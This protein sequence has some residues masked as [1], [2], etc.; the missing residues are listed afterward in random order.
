[1]ENKIYVDQSG[2]YLGEYSIGNIAIPA[3]AIEISL[4]PD[5]A[6]KIYN[7]DSNSWSYSLQDVKDKK[8]A[9]IKALRNLE[10]IKPMTSH[11]AREL[12]EQQDGSFIEGSNKYFVFNTAPTGN[13][14]TEPSAICFSIIL[15]NLTNPTYKLRYSCT[16]IEGENTRKGYVAIDAALASS[17]MSHA[18]TRNSNNIHLCNIKE[19]LISAC[20]TIEEVEA[21]DV[22]TLL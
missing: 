12:I 7:F 2:N 14:A 18:E 4:R 5:D 21:V 8:K 9:E 6:R 13:P 15:K 19:N 22:A 3:G 17:I 11:Q 20:T 1:M 16:I 10:N